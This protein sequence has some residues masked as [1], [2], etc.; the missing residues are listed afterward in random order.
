[1]T[2]HF[3]LQALLVLG[4]LSASSATAQPFGIAMGTKKEA[5]D[6]NPDN[7]ELAPGQHI[8]N[9][10][11]KPHSEFEQY[12]I[13]ETASHGVCSVFAISHSYRDDFSGVGVRDGFEKVKS[14]LE[15]KYGQNTTTMELKTGPILL[16]ADQWVESIQK[17]YRTHKAIWNAA[18]DAK[19]TNNIQEIELHVIARTRSMAYVFLQYNFETILDCNKERGVTQQ[20]SDSDKDAL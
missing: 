10:V 16:G 1:M 4:I 15:E 11:P 6:V 13:I 9:S 12:Y 19:L 17:E 18:S 3:L 2:R 20:D 5:L 8:L 7:A 14:Q